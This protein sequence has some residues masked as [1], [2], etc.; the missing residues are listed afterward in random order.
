[1]NVLTADIGLGSNEEG[2]LEIVQQQCC[3]QQN[4]GWR[5][6]I[7]LR[8]ERDLLVRFV[9]VL[10]TRED[11]D[12]RQTCGTYE[13]S[14]VSRSLCSPDGLL[15]AYDKFKVMHAIEEL[16]LNLLSGEVDDSSNASASDSFLTTL[17]LYKFSCMYRVA[18]QK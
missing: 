10:R 7:E 15:L 14:A 5:K 2:Y 11:I 1:M 16:A 12:L 13:F 18:Q 17:A 9:I 6:I 8:E 4:K 3:V